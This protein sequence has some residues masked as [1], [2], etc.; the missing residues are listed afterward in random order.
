MA[1][2]LQQDG[3]TFR[4]RQTDEFRPFQTDRTDMKETFI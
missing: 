1:A 4:Q 3:G 2:R